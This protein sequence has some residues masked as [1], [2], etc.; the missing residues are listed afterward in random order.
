MHTLPDL[1]VYFR[2]G[3]LG[4]QETQRRLNSSLKSIARGL[5]SSSLRPEARCSFKVASLHGCLLEFTKAPAARL[6]TGLSHHEG[7]SR[8]RGYALVDHRSSLVTAENPAGAS[9]ANTSRNSRRVLKRFVG[10][11]LSMA[12]PHPATPMNVAGSQGATPIAK[13][14]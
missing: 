7:T 5:V 4:R 2:D 11:L 13:G 6:Q 8:M 14:S 12:E 10:L 1:F 9:I 3:P